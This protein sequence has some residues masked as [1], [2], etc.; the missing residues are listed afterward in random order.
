MRR[1]IKSVCK[2]L[3]LAALTVTTTVAIFRYVRSV[4]MANSLHNQQVDSKG[5]MPVAPEEPQQIFPHV[6]NNVFS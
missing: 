4:D 3:V 5:A 1:S 6:S 2:F